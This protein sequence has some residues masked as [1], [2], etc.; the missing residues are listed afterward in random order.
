ETLQ[1]EEPLC[2]FE[3]EPHEFELR[4]FDLTNRARAANRL[5]PLI[6]NDQAACAARGHSIDMERN[7]FMRHTGSDG[8]NIR[9]RLERAGIADMQGGSANI[10]GGWLTP[11]EVVQAW[12]DSPR[13]RPN[14]LS[15]DFTHVGVGFF[16]RP[17]DSN[18]RFA[19]Y[20]TQKFFVFE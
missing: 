18:A 5:P 1:A 6:W 13:Y 9:D 15:R 10:A 3:F 16:R 12:M 17:A 14:I 7:N 20:W 11:E 8:L 19:T 4:V 2:P